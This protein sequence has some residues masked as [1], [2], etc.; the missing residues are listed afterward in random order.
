MGESLDFN[1][2]N[3]MIDENRCSDFYNIIEQ[4]KINNVLSLSTREDIF[5]YGGLSNCERK[6]IINQES[7]PFK[8]LKIIGNPK[9][10]FLHGEILGSVMALG[11]KRKKTG[12]IFI[13][14][15][16]AYIIV[17]EEIA[18]YLQTHLLTIGKQ[19]VSVAIIKVTSVIREPMKQVIKTINVSSMRV[20]VIVAT[21]Y[22]LARN[23]VVM[24]INGKK[25]LI[26]YQL[27]TKPSKEVSIGDIISF[28][29]KGRIIIKSIGKKTKKGRLQLNILLQN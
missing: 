2:L 5:L 1:R 9:S 3:E 6:A 14:G 23:K 18:K 10:I 21:L 19:Y 28:K 24:L 8:A 26:N 22:H 11:I 7:L 25:I 13:N 12:D 15:N 4:G 20:D 27:V 16:I 17:K 29:N